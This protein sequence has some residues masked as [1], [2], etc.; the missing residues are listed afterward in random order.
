MNIYQSAYECEA[1]RQWGAGYRSPTLHAPAGTG[2]LRGK[3][4]EPMTAT[5]DDLIQ[6]GVKIRNARLEA[7]RKRRQEAEAELARERAEA[8]RAIFA[9]FP[10]AIHEFCSI[11]FP[12]APIN[13]ARVRI[14]LPS[15][16]YV[17]AHV[18]RKD[19]VWGVYSDDDYYYRRGIAIYKA[20][21]PKGYYS[22]FL[23]FEEAIAHAAGAFVE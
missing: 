10:P 5:L 22:Q 2:N 20:W 21:D 23:D 11:H 9:L 3:E 6:K 15:G 1:R 14:D 17:V 18:E 12:S 7:E 16:G 13:H 8:E 19:G 4:K